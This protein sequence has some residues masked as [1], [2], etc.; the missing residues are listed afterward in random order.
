MKLW[1]R[2]MSL[3]SWFLILYT[4]P[5]I[6]KRKCNLI[7]HTSLFVS[8]KWDVRNLGRNENVENKFLNDL[9]TVK[10]HFVNPANQK[11]L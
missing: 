8:V 4:S 9:Q 10:A 7:A 5:C 11:F 6:F 1:L 2:S 3:A